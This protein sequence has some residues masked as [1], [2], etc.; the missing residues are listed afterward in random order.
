MTP[1]REALRAMAE[2]A[3]TEAASLVKLVC[4]L[5]PG[6][7]VKEHIARTAQRLG[8]TY[9]RT[10]DIW[11]REARRIDSWEMDMLRAAR[12]VRSHRRRK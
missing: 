8:W 9:C 10:E 7:K 2:A 5:E 3:R 1:R 4:A 11:R 12:M 6:E